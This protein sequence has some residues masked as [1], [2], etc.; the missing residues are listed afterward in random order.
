MDNSKKVPLLA[1][2]VFA[3]GCAYTSSHSIFPETFNINR[4]IFEHLK[5]KHTFIRLAYDGEI[6]H[7]IRPDKELSILAAIYSQRPKLWIHVT[8]TYNY[9][10]NYPVFRSTPFDPFFETKAVGR[11]VIAKNASEEEVQILL[12]EFRK[13]HGIDLQEAKSFISRITS[14]ADKAMAADQQNN[15]QV[16]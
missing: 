1:P 6:D 14:E 16:N 9:Q 7:T 3:D 13:R 12:A 2:N 15:S 4:R 8:G 11:T 5:G 10:T